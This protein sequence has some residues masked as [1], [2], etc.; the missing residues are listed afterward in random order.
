MRQAGP[1]DR[2]M[3]WSP[4]D[5]CPVFPSITCRAHMNVS[6]E[7]SRLGVFL[8]APTQ[9]KARL[10]LLKPD[11]TGPKTLRSATT[12]SL[13]TGLGYMQRKLGKVQVEAQVLDRLALLLTRGEPKNLRALRARVSGLR[14][15]ASLPAPVGPLVRA[16]VLKLCAQG[17]G[18][19]SKSP[20]SSAKKRALFAALQEE[21]ATHPECLARLDKAIEQNTRDD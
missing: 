3:Q 5:P 9:G 13:R 10:H 20:H 2:R 8:K 12:K 4:E 14:S 15:G 1:D 21:F 18:F 17:I 11:G 16:E 7:L 6:K 19:V